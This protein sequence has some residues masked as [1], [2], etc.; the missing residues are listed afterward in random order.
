[1]SGAI[2]FPY[3]S[4]LVSRGNQF[5]VAY[6]TF[7]TTTSSS[8]W[9]MVLAG[10]SP[11]TNRLS[12]IRLAGMR[13]TNTHPSMQRM[14]SRAMVAWG[15]YLS[16]GARPP[17]IR[18]KI[19]YERKRTGTQEPEVYDASWTLGPSWIHTKVVELPN[20]DIDGRLATAPA[21]IRAEGQQESRKTAP[22]VPLPTDAR[23]YK[24]AP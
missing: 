2:G 14:G 8:E 15:D 11:R 13:S 24:D 17:Y 19:L 6:I 5:F 3:A 1:M 22:T 4:Q 10:Y 16:T 9:A 7:P 20:P 12:K 18:P 23:T 21:E